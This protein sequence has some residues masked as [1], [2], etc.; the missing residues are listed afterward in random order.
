MADCWSWNNAVDNAGTLLDSASGSAG[1]LGTANLKDPRVGKIWRA[2]S[3]PAELDIALAAT[4]GVS[5]FGLFGCNFPALSG[6]T[7]RLGTGAGLGDLWEQVVEPSPALD[8]QAV[9]VLPSPVAASHATIVAPAG[10]PLEVGRI[11]I[12]GADWTPTHGHGYE[13]TG[14]RFD[15]LSARSRTPR[16]G[17][18]LADRGARLKSFTAHYPGLRPADYGEALMTMDGR[19]LAQQ[20]LFVPTP[21]T[22]D[23]HR[24]AV[25]GYLAEMPSTDWRTLLL[26]ERSITIQ[27]AG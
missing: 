21:G 6:L 22:Y 16:S 13:G 1:D 18:F 3:M 12:G 8:R 19:G 2:G 9:F 15:D 26:A 27:E 4:G 25:L 23:P 20:M 7:L 11:W 14:W 17:A 5:V 24:F 10:S